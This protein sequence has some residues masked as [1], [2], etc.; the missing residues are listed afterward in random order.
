MGITV[1]AEGGQ[2]GSVVEMNDDAPQAPHVPVLLDRCVDLL[3]EAVENMPPGPAAEAPV[4]IDATL[5]AGGHTA[6]L[7]A[8]LPR[9]SF[10]GIDADPSALRLA[11]LRLTTVSDRFTAVHARYDDVSD[12]VATLAIAGR[13]AGVLFDLGVS[14]MQLDQAER[15]FAY[16][17]D[18]P[19][20]MRMDPTGDLTAERILAEYSAVD[21]ARI[22]RTYGEERHA[23]RI[24]DAIVARRETHPLRTSAD[25]LDVIT[26]A[27]PA[28]SLRSGGHPGKR[29]FQALRIEVND[30]LS[31]LRRALPA[32]LNEVAVG[33][34]VVVMAYHSGEDRIVKRTFASV[35]EVAVPPDLPTIP[36]DARPR[37]A[38]VTRGAEVA[39][40][41]EIAA[42][43]R[44]SSVRLRAVQR[45]RENA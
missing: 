29:T 23:R 43:R 41:T 26:S 8:R 17:V 21:L 45:T 7:A 10:V 19:L 16:S 14:S 6:A 33:G 38:R 40:P 4:V 34:R 5:G 20:D 9:C 30:E 24:A 13:V 44:A 18:A 1:T 35:C 36:D 22:L 25:L 32:A 11:G 12:I 42:N 2:V 28:T 31:V 37:F 27:M 39:S 3:A 15:G